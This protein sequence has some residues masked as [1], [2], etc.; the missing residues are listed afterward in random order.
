MFALTAMYFDLL[1]EADADLEVKEFRVR[2]DVVAS[3]LARCFDE[4]AVFVEEV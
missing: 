3:L 4:D 2:S 1:P